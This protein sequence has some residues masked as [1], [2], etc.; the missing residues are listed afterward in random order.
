M[1]KINILITKD[2]V[3]EAVTSGLKGSSCLEYMEVLEKL[4]DARVEKS[5]YTPEFYEEQ[6][7]VRTQTTVTGNVGVEHNMQQEQVLGDK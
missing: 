7:L 6:T 4:F 5:I 3:I 2:G 1:K